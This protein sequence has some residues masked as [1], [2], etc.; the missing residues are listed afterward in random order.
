MNNDLDS[1]RSIVD[2]AF[3]HMKNRLAIIGA[4]IDSA[5][6]C[7]VPIYVWPFSFGYSYYFNSSRGVGGS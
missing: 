7:A 1:A 5:N 6:S 3:L 4:F 2:N